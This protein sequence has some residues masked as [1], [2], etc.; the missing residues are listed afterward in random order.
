MKY[1]APITAVSSPTGICA[2][3]MIARPT[4]SDTT[5]SSAPSSALTGMTRT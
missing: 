1:G 2:G 3:A 4:R 5:T